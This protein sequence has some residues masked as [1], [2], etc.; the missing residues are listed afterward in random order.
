MPTALIRVNEFLLVP[1]TCED[2]HHPQSTHFPLRCGCP[3]DQPFW[4]PMRRENESDAY[5]TLWCTACK[6]QC[7]RCTFEAQGPRYDY[8]KLNYDAYTS[9]ELVFFAVSATGLIILL[10]VLQMYICEKMAHKL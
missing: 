6:T 4:S 5:H 8:R 3:I 10:F 9:Y 7:F 2:C 1:S